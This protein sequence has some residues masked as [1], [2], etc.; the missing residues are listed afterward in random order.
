M[1]QDGLWCGAEARDKDFIGVVSVFRPLGETLAMR[2]MLRAQGLTVIPVP[3]HE[4][5]A[6]TIPRRRA[7]VSRLIAEAQAEKA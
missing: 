6:M 1:G 5:M 7:H 4:W 3:K 2:R